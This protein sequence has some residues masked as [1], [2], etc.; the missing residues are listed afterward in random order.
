VASAAS[1]AASSSAPPIAI[2][3]D[4]ERVR[5]AVNPLGEAPYSGP[6]GG[7]RGT[8]TVAGD[9]APEVPQV[10]KKFNPGCPPA[11]LDFY[12]KLFREGPGRRLADVVVTVTGY[13]GFV[14]AA[15]DAVRVEV[16]DCMYETRTI[17]MTF[18]QRIE[19]V[20]QGRR[21]HIPHLVGGSMKALMV[22]LPRGESIKLFPTQPGRYVLSDQMNIFMHTDVLVVKY[23]TLDV[24]GLAGEFEIGRIPVG[25]V[26]VTAFL[27]AIM[28]KVERKATIRE[29]QTTELDFT[30][31][32]RKPPPERPRGKA[33]AS[34]QPVVH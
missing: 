32:Y 2:P 5:K 10:H 11:A 21:A 33:A 9:P 24:T 29:N 27:P 15:S 17:G 26:T 16:R 22:A 14:P 28:T 12:G 3:V 34:A 8:V 6:V 7:V 19:V 18:G 31:K 1:A 30:M 25:E 13:Q 4:T 23:A 20:N